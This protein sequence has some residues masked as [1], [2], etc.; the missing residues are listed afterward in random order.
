M[1]GGAQRVLPRAS[2]KRI[3]ASK[4]SLMPEGL[5]AGIPVQGMADLIGYLRAPAN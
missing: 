3:A 4:V 1:T 2:V 5:E